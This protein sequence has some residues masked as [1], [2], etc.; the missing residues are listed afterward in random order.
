MPDTFGKTEQRALL[1]AAKIARVHPGNLELIYDYQAVALTYFEQWK[2]WI[3]AE[4]NRN[5]LFID[6]GHASSTVT[7]A[8]FSPVGIDRLSRAITMIG[9]RDFDRD[10]A[11]RLET[12]FLEEKKLHGE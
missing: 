12:D 11:A 5:V 7:F 6:V 8:Q 1:D 3:A 10:V 4:G 2:G 9:G